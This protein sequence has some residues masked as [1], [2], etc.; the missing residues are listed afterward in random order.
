M[1]GDGHAKR[2][3]LVIRSGLPGWLIK[4]L[5]SNGVRRLS[6]LEGLTDKQLLQLKGI[7]MKSIAMI[8]A[9]L[10]NDRDPMVH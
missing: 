5:R 10:N 4:V 7:G 3:D 2:S 9:E 6:R 1:P 8:R